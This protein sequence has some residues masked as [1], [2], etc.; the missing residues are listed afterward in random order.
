MWIKKEKE[1]ADGWEPTST[2][3]SSAGWSYLHALNPER[4]STAGLA[5]LLGEAG[6]QWDD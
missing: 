1:E 4:A 3:T 6:D 5:P 2:R